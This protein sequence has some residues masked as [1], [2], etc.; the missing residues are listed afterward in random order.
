MKRCPKCNK[1]YEDSSKACSNCNCQLI[2]KLENTGGMEQIFSISLNPL[3][4]FFLK[5]IKDKTGYDESVVQKIAQKNSFVTFKVELHANNYCRAKIWTYADGKLHDYSEIEDANGNYLHPLMF[6]EFCFSDLYSDEEK[7]SLEGSPF[8]DESLAYSYLFRTNELIVHLDRGRYGEISSFITREIPLDSVLF[9]LNIADFKKLE[10]FHAKTIFPSDRDYYSPSQRHRKFSDYKNNLF[11]ELNIFDFTEKV[12]PPIKEN[13]SVPEKE[14]EKILKYAIQ[15]TK[16]ITKL[17]NEEK[18]IE[19]YLRI[20]ALDKLLDEN[21][22]DKSSIQSLKEVLTMYYVGALYAVGTNHVTQNEWV[23]ATV[24]HLDVKDFIL[25]NHSVLGL[26]YDNLINFITKLEADLK[27]NENFSSLK[28]I[29][30][31]YNIEARKLFGEEKGSIVGFLVDASMTPL[32]ADH[33]IFS[34]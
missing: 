2:E 30:E 14:Q 1:S 31:N 6:H 12:F 8:L 34:K 16:A 24:K 10:P 19:G 13:D 3:P 11:W 22:L 20:V 28:A 4:A 17:A 5:T 23:A 32:F 29:R 33:V 9:R 21:N 25:G 26:E 18:Y 27:K 7:K 15:E